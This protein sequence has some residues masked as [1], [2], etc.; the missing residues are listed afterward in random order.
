MK[1][2]SPLVKELLDGGVCRENPDLVKLAKQADF[3]T[4]GIGPVW[5]ILSHIG[6]NWLKL[7]LEKQG[8]ISPYQSVR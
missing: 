1:I 4:S 8:I 5:P 2:M 6:L 7:V 3:L